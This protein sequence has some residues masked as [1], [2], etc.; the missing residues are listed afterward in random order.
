MNV[1]DV[2]ID[3]ETHPVINWTR[4]CAEE[5]GFR[6]VKEEDFVYSS[7]AWGSKNSM[8]ED[9]AEVRSKREPCLVFVK[10]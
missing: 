3:K 1:A 6:F 10:E 8:D 9:G 5:V 4:E 2:K 7:R